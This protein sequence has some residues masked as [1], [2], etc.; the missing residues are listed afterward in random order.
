M[1]VRANKGFGDGKAG[2]SGVAPKDKKL[3]KRG[4]V[5]SRP[6]QQKQIER[7]QAEE[8]EYQAAMK[9]KY[10]S[11]E[12]N[13]STALP[14]I[15]PMSQDSSVD[16]STSSSATVPEQITDRMLRRMLIFSGAP[17]MLGLALF[18][19]FYYLKKTQGVDIPVWVV[20]IVQTL[21]FGGG[22]L[23]ISYGILSSSWDQRRE[24]SVLGWNEFQA[25]LPIVLERFKK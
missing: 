14:A 15:P 18:P 13:D 11:R 12:G 10:A 9:A 22:L 8:Q 19:L 21:V 24:G 1:A 23:G 4:K 5:A 3:S 6:S 2:E 17:V 16:S 7:L 25:N 20:Y